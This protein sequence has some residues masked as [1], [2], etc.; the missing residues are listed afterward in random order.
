M[1]VLAL[2]AAT[3]V[4]CKA[5]T[6]VIS[7]PFNDA[8]ERREVGAAWLDTSSGQFQVREGKLNVQGGLN[9]PLWLRKRLPR[10]VTVE[11]DVM[12]KSQDGDIKIELFGDGESFDP[13]QG[14]YFPTGY[15]FV[16]GGWGNSLS[17][18]GKLGEHDDA[19][20]AS[21]PHTPLPQP[22]AAGPI[23]GEGA[24]AGAGTEAVTAPAGLDKAVV[25]GRTY[26][27]SITRKGSQIDWKVDGQPFL[28]WTDP[29]PLYAED[30]AYLAFNNWNAD[31]YFDNLSIR[32]VP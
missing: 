1:V 8:F 4:G 20:K 27:W 30:K 19:V 11:L 15:V 31:V 29:A 21:R 2:T 24:A 16:F 25:A 28:S 26:R 18:I 3:A 5:K 13:D 23:A 32:P 22:P 17:I 12:S 7:E 10:D 9:R 14:T 6:P